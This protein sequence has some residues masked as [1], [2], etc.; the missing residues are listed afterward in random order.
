MANGL[1]NQFK[2]C[3][4]VSNHVS[5]EWLAKR[6]NLEYYVHWE[7]NQPDSR[8]MQQVGNIRIVMLS[9]L[10]QWLH[11]SPIHYW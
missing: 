9:L 3:Y 5:A 11:H 4:R 8:I 7:G 10:R 1:T 2:E 6:G